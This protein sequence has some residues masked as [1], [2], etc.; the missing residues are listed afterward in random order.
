MESDKKQ[1]PVRNAWSKIKKI[2]TDAIEKGRDFAGIAELR[3]K[4][5][6]L[7][8]TN[9]TYYEDLG[10]LTYDLIE[11]NEKKIET[12]TAVLAHVKRINEIHEAISEIELEIKRIKAEFERYEQEVYKEA[13]VDDEKNKE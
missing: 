2:S 12:K 6:M 10:R 4:I 7:E 9:R 13:P 3:F 11:D 8:R 5:T 1:N